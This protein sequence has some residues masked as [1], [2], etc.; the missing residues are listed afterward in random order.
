MAVSIIKNAKSNPVVFGVTYSDV[1]L[2]NSDG[3]T[4]NT[5][6]LHGE[7]IFVVE[8]PDYRMLVSGNTKSIK[9]MAEVLEATVAIRPNPF[10]S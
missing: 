2:Y 7:R 6:M 9:A 3:H 5:A 10:V 4:A 8:S 1:T